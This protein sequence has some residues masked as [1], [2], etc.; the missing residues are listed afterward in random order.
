MGH[1]T[2]VPGG[3]RLTDPGEGEE[4][5]RSGKA[6]VAGL[7]LAAVV[8]AGVLVFLWVVF[9]KACAPSPPLAR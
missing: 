3:R 4:R 6:V 5:L 2:R 1:G 8:L 9:S 7:I